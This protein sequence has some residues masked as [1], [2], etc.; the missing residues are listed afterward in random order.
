[1]KKII[2]I[3]LL[4]GS[5]LFAQN[6]WSF[7]ENNTPRKP[8][9]EFQF[10]A[11]FFTQGVFNN[12][13]AKND[14]L[15]GQTV[16]RLF[17]QNTTNTGQQSLYFEQRLIPFIIYQPKLLDGKAI[18]RMAFEIDWTWG[19][20]SYGAGG[21]FGSGF[22]A[23][24]VNIQTQNIEVELIPFNGFSINLGLQ[25][26][27]DTPYNPYR[28][29]FSKMTQTGYRLAYWGSDAVGIS[30]RY[31]MDFQRFKAGYYQLWENN[32]NQNDDVVLWEFMY[33]ANITPNWTQGVSAWYVFDRA[34]GEGGVSI[35]GQGL[36]SNLTEYNGLFRFLF[37]AKPYIAD[38]FWLGTFGNYNPE[39]TL[40]RLSLNM[41]F[42]ANLGTVQTKQVSSYQKAV[43]VFGFSGNFR[44]GYRYGQTSNDVISVDVIYA[45]GDEDGL[46]DEVYNGVIT[47]NYY[48]SPGNIFIG[49][50][51]YLLYS[52]GNVVNRFYSAIPD[53][54]N[55]GYGQLGGVLNLSKSFIPHKFWGKVGAAYARSIF[56]PKGGGNSVGAE[57]NGMISYAPAIFMNI[58]LH[59]AY[60]WLGDF[61]DSG[62]VNSN[63][64]KRPENAYTLFMVFKWLLF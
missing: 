15:K 13:Y 48:G 56:A 20:A 39:Y 63:S 7:D 11:Y 47:S 32:I 41:F 3:L 34:N 28:T 17:G 62:L 5:N 12:I 52:H 53:L 44:A 24:Q 55:I 38:L 31:D 23:D 36:N 25:R 59:G 40:G 37:G 33:E 43:D 2:I 14:L 35:L 58:E 18:L 30:T 8:I 60:L 27:F 16:G 29:F 42:V 51:S 50:G 46:D 26:L 19:D 21:N 64:S 49:T 61:Y 57:I 1:M 9:K 10:F 4:I 22:N 45:S 54:S 6:K